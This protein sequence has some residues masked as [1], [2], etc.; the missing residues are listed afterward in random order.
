MNTM[1]TRTT[2]LHSHEARCQFASAD[3]SNVTP[4]DVSKGH[5]CV[6]VPRNCVVP[7]L[8]T[9]FEQL[10]LN[11]QGRDYPL[12]RMRLKQTRE[13]PNGYQLVLACDGCATTEQQ[14]WQLAYQLRMGANTAAEVHYDEFTLPKVPARGLYSE[15]ARQERL[16]FARNHTGAALEEVAH[17]RLEPRKLV[18]NIE[19]LIGSVEI[20]VG[21]AGPLHI[22]GRH[23]SGLFYAP[24]ATSEGA[25]VASATRGATALSRAGGVQTR[26]LGQR[27][28]RVP[29]FG[30][31]AMQQAL[32]FAEW[33]QDH[34][35]E[36]AAE[37]RKYSNFA[38][39]VEV[40][41]QVMGR[42]VHVHFIYETGDAAGQNMTTT[43]TWQACQWI[44]QQIKR[45]DGLKVR[46][47]LV[48]ANLSNDKKVT[49]QTFL[50]GRGVR[51]MAEV[52]LSEEVCRKVLKVTPTQLVNA[53]QNFVTGS[54]AAGMVGLNINVANVVAAMF[55]ALGQDIACVH[56]SALGQLHIELTEEG[57]AYCT[58]TLPS[59]VIGTVGG[60]TNLP[61]QRECLELI[62]CAGPGKAHKLAEVIAG[63]CLA[64]D[65]S[66]LSAIAADQFARAHERL[67]RNRPVNYL[68]LGDLNAEFFL[69]ACHDSGL[70]AVR[71]FAVEPLEID[72]KGSSIITELTSHKVNK[73]L[74]HFPFNLQTADGTLPVMAKVKPLDDEAIIM[75][76]SMAAMCDARLAQVFTQFRD[77]LGFKGCHVRE[78]AVMS[79]QDPRFTRYA[80]AVYGVV[81][82]AERE[83]YVIVEELLQG[84][85]LMDSAD[86]TSGWQ[87]QHLEA[88]ITG[89]AEVHSIWYGRED[90]LKAQD[91]LIDYPS[92]T[93]MQAKTRLWELLG[94]HAREE[95]PE[96][97]SEDDLNVFRSI[98]AGVGDWW[99]DIEAMPRTLIHNDFNPRNIALRQTDGE[100][101][102]CAYD[103]ELAT[104][105]LPQ[106]DLAELLCF[107]LDTPEDSREVEHYLEL[108]RQQLARASGQSI[109]PAQ[110]RYGYK[111]AL[112]DL[113]INRL[114]MYL[115]AH[116]FRHYPFMERVYRTSRRLLEL[117]GVRLS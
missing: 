16:A 72:S 39:L 80:P 32:F 61:Q 91:W 34:Y 88:A 69:A 24:M 6:A 65:I 42:N 83:A 27:M 66:T 103:W 48:E 86:D 98:V 101:R 40:Q 106:H 46:N 96:W 64:L 21:L 93:G 79:Q 62:D 67:G 30:F 105:H 90:E 112:R 18:S 19:A 12:Y 5:L 102:L 14:L 116:T 104:L 4:V 51:V 60:G 2:F 89:I 45:F 85:T 20:P 108:H 3:L 114:P 8:G 70:S 22:K 31:D 36:L 81:A 75:L 92:A 97:F 41:A 37:V 50:K 109:D 17:T 95:F 49:Y 113:L 10:T 28:M 73:L 56:E 55:T 74:G 107:T 11:V 53:Y 117:E 71:P 111:L 82:D 58:M 59:L 15:E 78:L 110:W 29:L 47:F 13:A 25:L 9:V 35:S 26:V 52:R 38:Q 7:A 115:M 44:L 63:Y 84:M 68:K 100:M 23:A 94:V 54:L 33:V 57:D 99:Q 76:S 43:C 87:R 1:A 77:E